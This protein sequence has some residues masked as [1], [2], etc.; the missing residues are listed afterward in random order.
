MKETPKEKLMRFR[1]S[2]QAKKDEASRQEK[3]ERERRE[4][5][6][7]R[8]KGKTGIKLSSL[9]IGNKGL[10]LTHKLHHKRGVVWCWRCGYY[11]TENPREL[12]EKCKGEVMRGN[13]YFLNR[14]KDNKTP[15]KSIEWPFAEGEG[16][17][18]GPV[19]AG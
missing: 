1:L 9:A 8:G 15:R 12:N 4:E 14:L 3:A 16:P 7:V 5:E 6:R 11:A 13:I 10:H 17:P 18:E 2:I 19:I